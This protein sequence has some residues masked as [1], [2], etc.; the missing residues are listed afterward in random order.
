MTDPLTGLSN[1]AALTDRLDEACRAEERVVLA[2]VDLNGFKDV[3]D[4]YGHQAGD[5][6]LVEVGARLTRVA[7]DRD[8]VARFGGDEF[9]VLFRDVPP[10]VRPN[11]L[12]ERIRIA[13]DEPWPGLG[14]TAV[15]A[16]VGVVDNRDGNAGPEELIR[17]ADTAMYSRKHGTESGESPQAHDLAGPRAPPCRDGRARWRLLRA[18]PDREP[19]RLDRRGG[20]PPRSAT[21]SSRCSAIRSGACSRS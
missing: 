6:V 9:V 4:T 2:F 3:N 5:A 12:V 21:R 8:V 18:A 1:R 17:I 11:A 15:T 13:L 14:A 10:E 19:R 16:S 20:E 7:R